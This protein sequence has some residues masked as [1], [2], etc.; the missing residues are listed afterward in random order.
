MLATLSFHSPPLITSLLFPSD[1]FLSF[2]FLL[3]LLLLTPPPDHRNH[4]EKMPGRNV[5]DTS[6]RRYFYPRYFQLPRVPNMF[7][8]RYL[9]PW[10]L[11]SVATPEMSGNDSRYTRAY[12]GFVTRATTLI[13]RINQKI[14]YS[15]NWSLTLFRT[16][17]DY[18]GISN[19]EYRD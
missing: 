3:A 18:R 19:N 7:Y 13:V 11:R 4:D 9:H 12:V 8:V 10:K 14:R 5:A 16:R 1:N 17:E 6:T 2:F 15:N